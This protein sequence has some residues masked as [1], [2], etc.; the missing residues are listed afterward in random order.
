M[1][2][3]ANPP[4][5]RLV[6]A[7]ALAVLALL[8]TAGSASAA[9]QSID[10]WGSF[11]T[12][13]GQFDRPVAISASGIVYVGDFDNNRIQYFTRDGQ[14]LDKWGTAGTADGQFNGPGEVAVDAAGNVYVA[15]YFNARIQ[16]FGPSGQFLMKF[17][18]AGSADGQFN[19]PA[20]VTV[21][22]AGFIYVTDPVLRRVQ[23]FNAAGDFVAKWGTP[24]VAD[25]QFREPSSISADRFG[26]IYVSDRLRNDVQRFSADGEFRG[27]FGGAG[28]GNGQFSSA[29][30]LA[31]DVDG[32]VYVTDI[33]MHNVQ[34]FSPSGA[35][36]ARWSRFGS[37]PGELRTP[38]SI[39][40]DALGDVYVAEQDAQRVQVFR[41]MPDTTQQRLATGPSGAAVTYSASAWDEVDGTVPVSCQPATGSIFAIG[42]TE[43]TC[44]ASDSLGHAADASFTVIVRDGPPSISVPAH[45]TVEATSPGG[46]PVE[47]TASAVDAVDG[48]LPVHCSPEPGTTFP[49]GATSV[50]CRATDSAGNSL[51]RAF[52]VIVRDT[53]PPQLTVPDRVVT[54]AT[55]PNGASAVYEASA[56]DVADPHPAVTCNPPSGSTITIGMTTVECRATDVSGNASERSFTVTVQDTTAPSIGVP[57]GVTVNASSP[58]GAAVTY[59]ASASDSVDGGIGV[60]CTPAS[61]G[62]F[63][64]GTTTVSCTAADAAGNTAHASF[65]VHVKGV[66]DQI[67]DIRAA[68]VAIDLKQ[69]IVRSLDGKLARIQEALLEAGQHDRPATCQKIDATINETQAQAGKEISEADAAGLIAD[70]QRVK[71]V[72]A[73]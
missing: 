33:S 25:G 29:W 23:K 28:I 48:D 65:P 13:D 40:V 21:D 54:E 17:G 67:A 38:A 10:H 15:D 36:L 55:G 61:G 49:L 24:G 68:I 22:P 32:N 42:S 6:L 26:N 59:G 5:L 60:A 9:Y 52:N 46:S 35:F 2:T 51:S 11:G 4:T 14:F 63:P 41:D 20:A 58:A 7:G 53:T 71:A 56:T 18:S 44:E 50:T 66:T 12:G 1:P 43:V 19:R 72:L 31:T 37:R 64:I 8:A 47:Y 16:K 73:C 45:T 30:A 34:K 69:G 27:R 70:L 62:V 39:A 57:D 3:V